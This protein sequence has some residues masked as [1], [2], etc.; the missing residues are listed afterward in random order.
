LKTDGRRWANWIWDLLTAVPGDAEATRVAR[1]RRALPIVVPLAIALAT[2]AW[3]LAVWSPRIRAVQRACIPLEALESEV[4]AE[5]VRFSNEQVD[6]LDALARKADAVL[7]RSPEDAASVL[8]RLAATAARRHWT[9]NFHASRYPPAPSTP[10]IAVGLLN[11]RGSL[12]ALGGET[13]YSDLLAWLRDIEAGPQRI[14]LTRLAICA[15][16]EGRCTAEITLRLAYR[17]VP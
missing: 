9:A 12:S 17:I 8:D 15:D 1:L 16:E 7:L 3:T 14:E 4:T 5:Q 10:G 13:S 6:G 11:V 2:A